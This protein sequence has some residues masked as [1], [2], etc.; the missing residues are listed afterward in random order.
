MLRCRQVC[1]LKSHNSTP[2]YLLLENPR[3]SQ[4]VH[5]GIIS[6]N[7][8]YERIR[9]TVLPSWSARGRQDPEGADRQSMEKVYWGE[10]APLRGS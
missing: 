2:L 7:E 1:N 8:S 9:E 4:Q 5:E 6:E 10:V 3:H